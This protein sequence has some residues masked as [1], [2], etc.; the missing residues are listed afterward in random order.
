MRT[1]PTKPRPKKVLEKADKLTSSI[2]LKRKLGSGKRES[3]PSGK[4]HKLQDGSSTR[5]TVLK[6]VASHTAPASAVIVQESDGFCSGT[7]KQETDTT[8]EYLSSCCD[9][10]R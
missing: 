2:S 3:A 9:F 4:K 5:D 1:K 7:V 8:G 6:L 10:G